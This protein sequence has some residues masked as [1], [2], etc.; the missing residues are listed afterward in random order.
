VCV[1][2]VLFRK[3]EQTG[4]FKQFSFLSV[5]SNYVTFGTKGCMNHLWKGG[6]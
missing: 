4:A 5:T 3:I 6:L 1:F 2:W